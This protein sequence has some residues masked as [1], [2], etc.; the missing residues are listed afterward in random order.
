MRHDD[1]YF[2]IFPLT[3]SSAY[4]SYRSMCSFFYRT[5]INAWIGFKHKINAYIKHDHKYIPCHSSGVSS[6]Y[7]KFFM[8]LALTRRVGNSS[9]LS[10]SLDLHTASSS[11]SH[12]RGF[13]ATFRKILSCAHFNVMIT[14]CMSWYMWFPMWIIKA[15]EGIFLSNVDAKGRAESRK[16]I[17][18]SRKSWVKIYSENELWLYPFTPTHT[19]GGVTSSWEKVFIKIHSDLRDVL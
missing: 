9:A 12:F 2:H 4:A 11:P 3:L 5:R 15:H 10:L 6:I 19:H 18:S 7:G 16:R 8:H 17:L 13:H 14:T 1:K